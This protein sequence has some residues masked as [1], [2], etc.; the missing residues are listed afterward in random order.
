MFKVSKPQ[1]PQNPNRYDEGPVV[2]RSKG[3]LCASIE[4]ENVKR[5]IALAIGFEGL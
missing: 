3:T 5:L 2:T 4:S 1:K